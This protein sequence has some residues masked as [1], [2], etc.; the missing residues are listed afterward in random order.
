MVVNPLQNERFYNPILYNLLTI[1]FLDL[2]FTRKTTMI[3]S[4]LISLLN[5]S[6]HLIAFSGR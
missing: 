4:L 3:Y 2:F 6:E 5:F 1:N